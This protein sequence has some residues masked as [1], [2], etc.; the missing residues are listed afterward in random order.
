M[1]CFTTFRLSSLALLVLVGCAGPPP[2][3]DRATVPPSYVPNTFEP[4]PQYEY[5]PAPA[6]RAERE[7]LSRL[8]QELTFLQRLAREAQAQR[9]PSARIK[10]DYNRLMQD[11]DAVRHGIRSHLREPSTEPRV[12]P[13][14]R[15]DYR[16]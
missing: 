5:L 15:G 9:N 2:A 12:F 14:I 3:P 10:F 16:S 8:E 11:L 7:V 4:V 1:A 13:P 6:S